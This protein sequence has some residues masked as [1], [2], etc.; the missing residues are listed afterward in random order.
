MPTV[1]P[2]AS[3]KTV[4]VNRRRKTKPA[5]KSALKSAPKTAR[6]RTPKPQT[7]PGSANPPDI[8]DLVRAPSAMRAKEPQS[9]PLTSLSETPLPAPLSA[10]APL[11]AFDAALEEISE[12]MF[13]PG[14]TAPGTISP[15]EAI[16]LQ[17]RAQLSD[18]TERSRLERLLAEVMSRIKTREEMIVRELRTANLKSVRLSSGEQFTEMTAILWRLPSAK[19]RPEDRAAA[20][21]WLRDRG[22]GIMIDETVHFKKL[23]GHLNDLVAAKV[24]IPENLFPRTEQARLSIT[25]K[26]ATP[27]DV[28]IDVP[29]AG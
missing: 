10:S 25:G 4:K 1:A 17:C 15:I 20:I 3:Q 28:I 18:M 13:S 14:T 24:E 21:Q 2:K 9:P 27:A 22:D 26:H 11:S 8:V 6:K 19:D 16:Q 5:E 12:S 7:S 29:Q 23:E